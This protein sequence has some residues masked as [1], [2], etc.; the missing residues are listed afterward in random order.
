MTFELFQTIISSYTFGGLTSG[1]LNFFLLWNGDFSTLTS[2]D[3][4]LLVHWLNPYQNTS[5]EPKIFRI[6]RHG[7]I[8]I[9]AYARFHL[10]QKSYGLGC[11]WIRVQSCTKLETWL[12]SHYRGKELRASVHFGRFEFFQFFL[13][14]WK[15]FCH[16]IIFK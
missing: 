2:N 1:R 8:D 15:T 14:S 13:S 11:V 10:H 6:R 12:S 5:A 7:F 9:W 3:N 4:C 16:L